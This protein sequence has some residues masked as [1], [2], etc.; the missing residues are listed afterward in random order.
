M[1]YKCIILGTFMALLSISC[2]SDSHP[3]TENKTKVS[4]LQ[5]NIT[6]DALNLGESLYKSFSTNITRTNISEDSFPP[7]FGGSY[8]KNEHLVVL[9]KNQDEDG[10]KDIYQRIGNSKNI[11]IKGCK[12]S[13]QELRALKDKISDI[14]INDENLREKLK[15]HSVGISIEKNRIVVFL[16]D[17]SVQ[18]ISNFK[19][20]ICDSSMVIFEKIQDV[21]N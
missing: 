16:K 17:I 7:Y 6:D 21:E 20:L 8:Y 1:E 18:N 15:W 19:S 2:S 5:K 10:I 12:Y 13:L 14:Y 11:E 9:V 4:D 3:S